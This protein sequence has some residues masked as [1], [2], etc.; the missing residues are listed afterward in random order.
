MPENVATPELSPELTLSLL[1]S[2][3]LYQ[4]VLSQMQKISAAMSASSALPTLVQQ[5]HEQQLAA[6]RH[7]AGL[8]ELLQQADGALAHHP[9]Y[10][11]RMDLIGQVLQ[12]NRLLLPNINGMMALIS[13]ELKQVHNGRVVMGGYKQA[14]KK[15]GRIVKS[16]V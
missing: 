8:L 3:E 11:Q 7:D 12:L 4:V 10:M 16:S 15:S 1:T 9:L 2:I 6:Q 14:T 13:H 5:L